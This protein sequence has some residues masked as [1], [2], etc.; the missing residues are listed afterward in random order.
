MPPRKKVEIVEEPLEAQPPAG[1]V[2]EEPVLGGDSSDAEMQRLV[3]AAEQ[4]ALENEL[5]ALDDEEDVSP[6][7]EV[8]SKVVQV[9]PGSFVVFVLDRNIIEDLRLSGV[10]HN[11]LAMGD[12][13]QALVI[14][15]YADGSADLRIFVDAE[16]VPL[17]RGVRQIP[18]PSEVTLDHVNYFYLEK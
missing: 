16:A 13:A 14:K 12:P 10:G 18:K 11:T 5:A 4:I 1:I 6:P 9:K 2:L 7:V 17:R 15:S 3:A 8:A